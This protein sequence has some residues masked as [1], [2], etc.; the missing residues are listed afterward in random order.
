MSD[1]QPEGAPQPPARLVSPRGEEFEVAGQAGPV[2]LLEAPPIPAEARAEL[3]VIKHDAVF[4]CARPDGDI[5]PRE[6]SGEGLYSED[7]RY[8]SELQVGFGEVSPVLLSHSIESGHR[9]VVNAT[10]P[11]LVDSTGSRIPQETINLRRTLLVSDRLHCELALRS[12]HPKPVRLPLTVTVGADFAD[13]FEIR[14]VRWRPSRGTVMVPKAQNSKV[15][16]GYEGQD[17]VFRETLVKLDPAPRSSSAH[18]QQATLR[19]ELTLEPGQTRTVLI[20]VLPASGRHQH[21]PRPYR[22]AARQLDRERDEWIAGAT[23]IETDNELVQAVLGASTRD[24]H[25]LLTTLSGERLPAAGIPWYVAPFGRDSLI[26]CCESMLLAPAMARGTLIALAALQATDDEPWRD[27]E[28]GKILHELRCGELAKAGLIPHTPYYGTVDATPLFVLLAATYHRWTGDL[29]T[30]A[31]LLPALD[32][33]LDWIDHYG[34]A[35]GDGFVEYQRRSPAGLLNQGWKDS[36]DAVLHADGRPAQ[37]PI[38]L[39]EVQGYVYMAKLAISDLYEA[40]GHADRARA[41]REQAEALREA[42]NQAFWNEREGIYVLALDGRKRQVASVTSNPGHCLYCGIVDPRRADAVAQ[43]LMADD[44]FSGWGVRTL[45]TESPAYNPM[46]YHNG[47]VWPHD[48]AIIAAGLKRYGH[49]EATARIATAMFD[50]AGRARDF[51]LAELYCGFDRTGTSE[52]VGYPVACMP[53][54]WAA[55]APFMLLQAMLGVTPHAPDRNLSIIQPH[56]PSWL[57]RVELRRMRLGDARVSLAFTQADGITG[58][59]LLEQEG[60]VNVTMSAA[61]R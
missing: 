7:T 44:M 54:A 30:L 8:L 35:D 36:E 51:R 18:A 9:A 61:P 41:L 53:Q 27:A 48:N 49:P 16:F 22:H 14:G 47:S 21:A 23:R 40:L 55:A 58:F 6:V 56:V 26:T 46:S 37:G 12:F 5:R 29:E 10:N 15:L 50:I 60:E 20:T 24:L 4:L 11:V 13:V 42:F 2:E 3:L 59:S 33:A 31:R 32:A 25:A 1:L 52:I 45:S 57:G 34:D 38:A 17:G 19:W 43:R 28:P 39:V